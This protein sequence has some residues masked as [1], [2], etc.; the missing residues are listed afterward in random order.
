[1]SLDNIL[2]P[3]NFD[4]DPQEN[5]RI[6]NELIKLK[7]QAEYGASFGKM[8]DLSPAAER[9]FL[10]MVMAYENLEKNAEMVTV[11]DF[12]GKPAFEAVEH[13]PASGMAT[14]LQ[15][16]FNLLDE[17]GISLM[18]FGNY[19]PEVIYRFIT[20][21]LFKEMVNNV[22]VPGMVC[23]FCYE[24]FHRNH[25]MEM[26]ELTDSFLQSWIKNEPGKYP[27]ELI[28]HAILPDGRLLSQEELIRKIKRQRKSYG[29]M[30]DLI[31]NIHNRSHEWA[32]EGLGMG[33]TE[34]WLTYRAETK[35]GEKVI[36][37]PFK[38]YFCKQAD[39][40]QL[41]FFYLPGFNW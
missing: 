33:F 15:G 20:E 11:F 4:A 34:G 18:V 3:D 31:Y 12:L 19:P 13:I 36:Q 32:P 40:W 17:N 23:V 27:F 9:E 10:E 39:Y 37:G 28:S 7:M 38:F 24:D 22:R 2:G 25:E 6:G 35:D 1:M 16:M 41:A 8:K 26:Q 21:E 29:T 14:A 5:L 30:Q